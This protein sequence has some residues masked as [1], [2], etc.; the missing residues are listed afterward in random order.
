[1][2]KNIGI[3]LAAVAVVIAGIVAFSMM[4]NDS[5]ETANT[6]SNSQQSKTDQMTEE[7]KQDIIALASSTESLSTLVAAVKAA[8]L[9]ETLQG[10]GP[11]TV[12][13]PTND[14]FAKLPA[15]TVE[16]LLQPENKATLTSILTYHVIPGKVMAADLSNGQK[17]KT[18]QGTE[19]TVEITD[20]KVYFV[21]AKGGKAMVTT[22]DVNAANGVVHIIDTV[23]MYQ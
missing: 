1:M 5:N 21:D 10:E 20:G 14:A 4:N 2:N 8:G 12:L 17:V 23:L 7:T 3:I 18:V 15:G 9:V 11:F 16:T 22:A 13:A 19:L 6:S